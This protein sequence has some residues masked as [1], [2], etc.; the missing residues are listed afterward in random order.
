MSVGLEASVA[1]SGDAITVK[2]AEIVVE[3][4]NRDKIQVSCNLFSPPY[5][6]GLL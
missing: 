4:Q 2:K 6:L 1:D 5:L 3:S